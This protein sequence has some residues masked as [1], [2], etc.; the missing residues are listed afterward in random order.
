MDPSAAFQ[1]TTKN[2]IIIPATCR[3]DA[4]VSFGERNEDTRKYLLLAGRTAICS[5]WEK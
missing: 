5:A 2:T 4:M 3:Q 1:I